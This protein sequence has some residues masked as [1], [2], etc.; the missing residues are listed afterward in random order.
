MDRQKEMTGLET[1]LGMLLEADS[2][3]EAMDM[4]LAA[5]QQLGVLFRAQIEY[6]RETGEPDGA[7]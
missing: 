4:Y 6:I 3:D 7:L 2:V 1:Y 5:S